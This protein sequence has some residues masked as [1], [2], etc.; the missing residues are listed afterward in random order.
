MNRG[1]VFTGSYK[2]VSRAELR[3]A[4]N[5]ISSARHST[6]YVMSLIILLHRNYA[7]AIHLLVFYKRKTGTSREDS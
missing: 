1:K 3:S 4:E 7:E 5:F 2:T 6:A